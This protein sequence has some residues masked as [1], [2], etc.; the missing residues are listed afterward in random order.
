MRSTLKCPW[1][2]AAH[3]TFAIEDAFRKATSKPSA[4]GNCRNIRN[5]PHFRRF[6]R[7]LLENR[8]N[9]TEADIDAFTSAG[10]SKAHIFEVVLGSGISMTTATTTNVAGTPVEG[11]FKAQTW[12]AA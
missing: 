7:V 1:T 10:Y 8:G 3:S 9:A 6:S 5:T 4:P 11:H 12:A 2:V